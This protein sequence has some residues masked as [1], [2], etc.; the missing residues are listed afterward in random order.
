MYVCLRMSNG[1]VWKI[2]KVRHVPKPMRNLISVG[3]LDYEGH[4]VTFNGGDWK[5]TEGAM[6]GA[7]SAAN[8][9]FWLCKLEHMNEKGMKVLQSKRKLPGLNLLSTNYVKA[10]F[11]AS[12]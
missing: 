7:N 1:Y 9:D 8:S 5:V 4:N 3:Q 11:L 10:I 2:H 12:R 6:V